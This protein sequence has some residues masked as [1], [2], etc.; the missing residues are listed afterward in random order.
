[1][2]AGSGHCPAAITDSTAQSGIAVDG[3]HIWVTNYNGNSV[4]ELNA[5]DGSWIRT[6]S[7]PEYGFNTP[8]GITS[9][10]VH[11]WVTN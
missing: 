1:M 2:A 10:G 8:D 5:S 6:V 11:M 7:G 9:D 3:T 4:T